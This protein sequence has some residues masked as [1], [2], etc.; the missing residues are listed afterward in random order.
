MR[1]R[2]LPIPPGAL[3]DAQARE[4]VRVWAASGQQHLSLA[5]GL[6]EDPAAWGIMLVDLA[7]HIAHAY[8]LSHGMDSDKTLARIREGFDAEWSA[9]T[10]RDRIGGFHSEDG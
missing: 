9:D 6:W 4:L 2:E 5:N 8:E 7:R 3:G 10:D 1:S